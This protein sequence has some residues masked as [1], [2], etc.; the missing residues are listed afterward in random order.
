MREKYQKFGYHEVITPQIFDVDLFHTSGHYANYRENMYFSK[1]DERDFGLKPMNCPGHCLLYQADVNLIVIYLGVSLILD[2]CIAMSAVELCTASRVC[3]PSAR[4]TLT[5]S[6]VLSSLQQEIK[7][8]MTM[9]NEVYQTLGMHEYLIYLSTRP[10]K[11]MGTDDYW[12]HAEGALSEALK[13][14]NLPF[15]INPGDGPFTDQS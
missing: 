14:L 5:F 2:A 13:A 7:N 4:T 9:L 8:F 15:T 6:A 10:E 1:V 12:D 3:A 11:R